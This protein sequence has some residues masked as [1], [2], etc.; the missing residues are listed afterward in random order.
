M[1]DVKKPNWKNAPTVESLKRD[2]S[3]AESSQ[4]VQVNKIKEWLDQLNLEGKHDPQTLTTNS[5]VQPKVIRKHCEWRIP[6][7][8]EPFLSTQDLFSISPVSYE[9]TEGALQNQQLLNYQFN[10]KINKVEFIDRYVRDLVEKGTAI[11][12]TCWRR[13]VEERSITY[14]KYEYYRITDIDELDQ[15]N[16]IF[17]AFDEDPSELRTASPDLQESYNYS[18][19][20]GG[21]YKA[22]VVGQEDVD[23][24]VVV[25][26]HPY[27]EMCDYR[28][29]FFDPSASG[30]MANAQY[31]IHRM[32][33]SRS[34]LLK[35]PNVYFDI[36]KI[37]ES[38]SIDGEPS[39]SADQLVDSFDDLARKQIAVYEYWGYWDIYGDNTTV[40]IV[41]AWCGETLIRLEKNP[42][43]DRKIPFDVVPYYPVDNSFYGEPEATLILDNQRTIGALKRCI[44]DLYGKSAIGQT[45]VAKGSFSYRDREKFYNGEDC[46]V[47]VPQNKRIEDILYQCSSNDPSPTM[48]SVLQSEAAEADSLTGSNTYNTGVSGD[49]LGQTAA[50]ANHALS[51]SAKRE[52]GF[53]R[54]A[55]EGLCNIGKKMA[56]LNSEY[57]EDYEIIRITNQP[58]IEIERDALA[59]EFDMDIDI[60]T[61]EEDNVKAQ[62]LS[63]MLQTIGP[64]SDQKI[65]MKILSKIATL[66]KMP[67]LAQEVL[68]FEPE[69]DP[70]QE[71]LQ[72]LELA[73]I[74]A[75]IAETQAKARK[76]ISDSALAEARAQREILEIQQEQDGT[77]HARS[78]DLAMSQMQGVAK[79]KVVEEITKATLNTKE[80]KTN[81]T[82]N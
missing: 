72:Q 36:D 77:N 38:S 28:N 17:A 3:T 33:T 49:A 48:L 59:V 62:K 9:D 56:S 4:V 20:T 69:P 41:A 63:F 51:S 8:T 67:D 43:P 61:I 35:Q 15:F 25:A 46:E 52:L 47:Q 19:E 11:V 60:S 34:E 24:Q 16:E 29:I 12:K 75:K 2:L 10:N 45:I 37:D 13:Q 78:K 74:E 42:Y 65:V 14:Y 21:M 1:V 66:H 58:S 27:P 70:I 53:L 79:A 68:E 18:K 76:A 82:T 81:G 31:L 80:G 32:Y 5:K 26:N 7:L 6:N 40:P 30:K 57:L 55:K 39:I 54:R 64:N 22:I 50:G 73:E 23:E 44:N 71:K